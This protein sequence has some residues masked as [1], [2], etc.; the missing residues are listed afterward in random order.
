MTRRRSN[1][2][3]LLHASTVLF[4]GPAVWLL[5]FE[6]T[7]LLQG[8]PWGG[9][10]GLSAACYGVPLALLVALM[11]AAECEGLVT[12]NGEYFGVVATFAGIALAVWTFAL[13]EYLV[14]AARGVAGKDALSVGVLSGVWVYLVLLVVSHGL[15]AWQLYVPPD[16]VDGVSEGGGGPKSSSGP[17][18]SE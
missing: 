17:P 13:G 8:D 15:L 12:R 18:P 1:P 9:D 7:Y 16:S 14:T 3:W 4:L 6:A 10:R 5:G 11:I 2:R